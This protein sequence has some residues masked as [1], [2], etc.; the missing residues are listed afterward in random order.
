MSANSN[1]RTL[2]DDMVVILDYTL[3]VDGE[4]V[5][6]S[7]GSEPIQFLQGHRNI[8]PGL[9]S[10]IYGLK[11]GESKEVVIAPQDGYGEADPEAVVD[12]PREE[13]P[14]DMPLDPGTQL[15]LKDPD[16]R[17]MHAMVISVNDEEVRLDFNHPL[18]G[19]ELHFDITLV[20]LRTATDEELTHGHV[21]DEH[22]HEH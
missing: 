12:V 1:P 22:G 10:E 5:D 7:D 21:H 2:A 16:G 18:A 4:I 19:K 6:T 20:G 17:A 9:E 11:V 8:I 14:D 3:T 13:F 15:S